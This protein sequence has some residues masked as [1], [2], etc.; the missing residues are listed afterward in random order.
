M[1]K[2]VD[3]E[4]RKHPV[5]VEGI[6]LPLDTVDRTNSGFWRVNN[7]FSGERQSGF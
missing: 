1:N 5:Q 4:V 6:T 3:E 7:S 2:A